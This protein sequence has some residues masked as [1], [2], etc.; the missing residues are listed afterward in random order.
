MTASM[1]SLVAFLALAPRPLPTLPPGARPELH[2]AFSEVAKATEKGDF[3]AAKAALKRLPSTQLKIEWDDRAVPA[4]RRATFVTER[5]RVLREWT[6]LLSDFKPTIV[7]SGGQLRFEFADVLP[8]D[9]TTGFPSGTAWQFSATGERKLTVRIGLRRG[10]PARDI[11]PANV[12]NEVARGIG[13]YV[14]LTDSPYPQTFMGKSDLNLE[15]RSTLAP[16]ELSGAAAIF[17]GV[18]TL[19]Q[20]V[21]ERASIADG[22]PQSAVAMESFDAGRRPQG[23]IVRFEI[24]IRNAGTSTLTYRIVPD[25]GCF[26]LGAARPVAPGATFNVPVAMDT[27]EF[28][29]ETHKKLVLFTNDPKAPVRTIPYTV[30]I[31]PRYRLIVPQ[32]EVLQVPKGG[33][34]IDLYLVTPTGK[35]LNVTA[36]NLAGVPATASFSPW[37]GSLADAVMK[38]PA[39]PREGTKVSIKLGPDFPAGRQ[40]MTV[41]VITDDPVFATLRTSLTLQR[42]IASLPSTLFLGEVKGPQEGRLLLSRPGRPFRILG[43]KSDSPFFTAKEEAAE[44]ADVRILVRYVGQADPGFVSGLITVRTDDPD[45]PEITIPVQAVVR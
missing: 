34:T 10:N 14:G 3:A 5:E 39:Q 6:R 9:P 36:V 32:E 13:G 41:Q 31:Q 20:A 18:S 44:G 45:Q 1:L 21:E 37:K 43:V 2:D 17:E 42:G 22:R 40:M 33:R 28:V 26:T 4:E 27:T 23:E 16:Y 38:E 15:R 29:G 25:C 7:P 11:D 35:P 12:F 24:P 19:T 30:F 8:T